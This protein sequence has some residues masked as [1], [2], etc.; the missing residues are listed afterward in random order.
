METQENKNKIFGVLEVYPN[1]GGGISIE[2]LDTPSNEPIIAFDECC[3][4]KLCNMIME[5]AR[6]IREGN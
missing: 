2:M 4:E 6:Q 1:N 3:A 5:V